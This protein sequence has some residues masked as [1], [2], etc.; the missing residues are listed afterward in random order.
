M[1]RG[2]VFAALATVLACVL[3]SPV[4]AKQPQVKLQAYLLSSAP[5]SLRDL[6]VHSQ[7]IGVLYPTYFECAPSSG[8][9]AGADSPATT[10]YARARQ[11]AVMPRFNCQN[12]ATVHSILTEPALR[13]ATIARLVA[14]ARDPSYQGLNIDFENDGAGDREAL[15]AFVT[16]LAAR[17]HALHKKLAVVVDGVSE[18]NARVSTGFYDDRALA[19]VADTVFVLAWGAH[20]EASAPGAIAPLSTAAATASYLAS[21]PD[22]SHFVLGAPM[23]GLDW[24]AGGGPA[25][26]ATAYQYTDVVALAHAE[27][28]HVRRDPASGELTFAYTDAAGVSHQVWYM[29][30]TA[31]VALLRI[32]HEHGLETGLWRLGE[33]D[34]KNWSSSQIASR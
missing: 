7:S 21:L 3:S 22:A 15:T 19:A 18:D 1:R 24:P 2:A 27:H 9:V 28:A 33:E 20:W 31:V 23:Y 6:Q 8:S 11:I 16:T 34:Q 30:T 5:D 32:A 14:I 17:L 29:D 4:L 13:A 26:P 25:H 12:G 10:A